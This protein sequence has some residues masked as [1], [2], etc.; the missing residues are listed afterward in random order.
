VRFSVAIAGHEQNEATRA[1]E[2]LAEAIVSALRLL[3]HE[4]G[5]PRDPLPGRLIVLGAHLL[6]SGGAAAR[7]PADAIVFN[8]EQVTSVGAPHL[9][10]S[11]V[12]WDYSGTN[13]EALGALGVP[14]LVHCPIG[15]VPSMTRIQPE[16]R[17]P[18]DCLF[19]GAMNERRRQVLDEVAAAGVGL[20]AVRAYGAPRDR[21]IA[22]SKVVLNLH[23]YQSPIFEVVRC[24]HLF[25]NRRCVLTEAGGVDEELEELAGRAAV[26]SPRQDIAQACLALRAS[27]KERRAAAER[28]FEEFRTIDFV[29]SVERALDQTAAMERR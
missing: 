7:V 5:S 2:D 23:Y 20:A 1:F 22:Q 26:V 16:E 14:R 9:M 27:E 3:G 15:Y 21:L 18:I 8:T 19:Y 17:E 13:I 6:P 29:R 28:G 11:R 25:A 10:R 24:S 12:V 4:V